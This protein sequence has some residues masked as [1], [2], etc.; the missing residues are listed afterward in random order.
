MPA[1]ANGRPLLRLVQ[2]KR[3]FDAI[4]L[5]LGAMGS[6]TLY[7]LAKRANRGL[8]VLGIDR[9]SPPH[10]RGSSHGD[11]RITRLS[12]G[13]GERYSPLAIRSHEIW[14]EI[15][16][17]TGADL[18]TQTG[19]LIISSSGPRA[20]CHVPGFF[21]NTLAAARRY[22]I[23]HELLDARDIRKRFP[24]F[25]VG[26]DEVG[27]FEPEAGYLR[28]EACVA[29]QLQL[30]AHH[31]ATIHRNELALSF[32][33]NNGIVRLVTEQGEYE[34][35]KLI[36]TT[37]PW[38]PE[39]AGERFARLLTVRRQVLCWFDVNDGIETF[40]P[41]RFPV[42]IWEL[43]G[44]GQ[45]IYGFPAIDGPRGGVKIATEQFEAAT[46]PTETAR[47]AG[48]D[49]IRTMHA[50]N[51]APWF[52]GLSARCVKALTC[53][54]TMTPD[55]HFLVDAHP[56]APGVIVAS[57][58][59]GHGFKHSAAIGEALAKMSQGEHNLLDD[60]A[61]RLARFG[62]GSLDA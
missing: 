22:S 7:Q 15:E 1:K 2:M 55:F 57:P 52:P 20:T 21:Q 14:R 12:I 38:L 25:N 27:Y 35:G 16:R 17:G 31:G 36:V 28:P 47:T 50:N 3:Q 42:F 41:A 61:F 11:T 44:S 34:T 33:E 18:L 32:N 45:A 59:S 23:R 53:L 37:G 49:E 30:A 43:P 10:D 40:E 4:V 48:P 24:A 62:P 56:D 60:D 5:G 54:Y 29:A 46:T 9:Y 19:G 58:C 39:L 26:D 51:I 8:R 13:E 6:A